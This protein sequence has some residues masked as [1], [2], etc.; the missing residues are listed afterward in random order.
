MQLRGKF[1][2][3][4]LNKTSIR[5]GCYLFYILFLLISCNKD[6]HK[7]HPSLEP[8]T[9]SV[10]ASGVVK[11]KNQYQVYSAASGI[12]SRILVSKGDIISKGTPL[13]QITNTAAKLNT[14][15]AML[16]ARYAS[17]A[18]NKEKLNELDIAIGLA[19]TKLDNDLSLLQRQK[20]LWAQRIGTSNEL[21]AREL[22]YKSSENAYQTA[23]LRF[24]ELQKQITFQQE[25]SQK[26]LE[27][28]RTA[29][30]D[31][32]VRSQRDGKVYDILK[33]TGEMVT[34]ANP[35]A[36]VGAANDFLLELQIDEYDITSIR[37]GQKMLLTMDSYKGR[38]FEAVVS[39]VIP[40]MNERSKSFT[41]EA[42]FIKPPAVLYP[43]L[44]CEANIVIRKKEKA[45]TI[46]RNYLM[47]GDHVLLENHEKRK[48]VTGLK[49]YQKVE[50]ISGLQAS[51]V[52]IMPEE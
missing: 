5:K 3:T 8:V 38:I 25:Q 7:L 24:A 46:P 2:A 50:I 35:V 29:S 45:L 36:I 6:E 30:G 19:K 17:L 52:I 1:I 13:M 11:S 18:S 40:V 31:F 42:E 32:T 51:D 15:N 22:A 47:P 41:I 49:D 27:I 4:A 16:N 9:E 23:K 12:I 34:T 37:T 48:V 44:T 20:N 14:E 21:D 28:S 26:T 10:Y 43:N 33:E 39:K